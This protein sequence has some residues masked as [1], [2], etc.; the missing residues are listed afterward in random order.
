[1][2]LMTSHQLYN[3]ITKS[4]YDEP[5]FSLSSSLSF[6]PSPNTHRFIPIYTLELFFSV[7]SVFNWPR[8]P[9]V[10]RR[11]KKKK[12]RTDRLFSSLQ[13]RVNLHPPFLAVSTRENRFDFDLGTITIRG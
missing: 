5:F 6:P 10:T 1:M 8:S 2:L 9:A 4:Q 3:L 12:K 11:W 13:F 7:M